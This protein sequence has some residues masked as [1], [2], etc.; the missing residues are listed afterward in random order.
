MLVE[1]KLEDD[2]DIHPVIAPGA[3][4]LTM[5]VEFP[6]YAYT[7]GA[8]APTRAAMRSARAA[9]VRAC[10]TLARS[11]FTLLRGRSDDHRR[12]LLRSPPRPDRGGAE[13]ELAPPR[14]G[15]EQHLVRLSARIG[16]VS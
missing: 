7:R 16:H 14:V 10:G 9:L 15:R 11:S 3:T 13:R 12:R 2:V 8:P 4:S 1:M 5:I 6:A